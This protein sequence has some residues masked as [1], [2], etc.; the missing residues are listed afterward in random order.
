MEGVRRMFSSEGKLAEEM[1]VPRELGDKPC[2]CSAMP[3]KGPAPS[4]YKARVQWGSHSWHSASTAPAPAH[5]MAREVQVLSSPL[6]GGHPPAG[7]LPTCPL[8]CSKQGLHGCYWP[9]LPQRHPNRAQVLTLPLFLLT[10]CNLIFPYG[11]DL[12]RLVYKTTWGFVLTWL[13]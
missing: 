12:S 2:C 10:S 11:F 1:H 6:K 13:N 4:W 3:L 5:A 7:R 9:I 8:S